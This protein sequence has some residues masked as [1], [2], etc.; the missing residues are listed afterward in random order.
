[1]T[2]MWTIPLTSLSWF[3]FLLCASTGCALL[4]QATDSATGAPEVDGART[5]F[6]SY[7]QRPD[8]GSESL[9]LAALGGAPPP[10]VESQGARFLYTKPAWLEDPKALSRFAPAARDSGGWGVTDPIELPYTR[11]QSLEELIA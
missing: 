6:F 1:M 5:V 2:G 10:L 11:S 3:R 8:D 4:A 7:K 9:G